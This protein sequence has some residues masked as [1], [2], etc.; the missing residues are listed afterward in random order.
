MRLA[1]EF[2]EHEL[3]T[4]MGHHLHIVARA[5]GVRATQAGLEHKAEAEASTDLQ[6]D[7]VFGVSLT[8]TEQTRTDGVGRAIIA[9]VTVLAPI[10]VHHSPV[11]RDAHLVSDVPSVGS[12]RSTACMREAACGCG[13]SSVHPRACAF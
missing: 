4:H 1:V 2:P 13:W 3:G 7:E 12:N 9:V 11:S 6:D 10:S 8:A 5:M